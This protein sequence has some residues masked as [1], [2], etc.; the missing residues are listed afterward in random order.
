MKLLVL[1]VGNILASDDGFGIY[2][3]RYLRTNYSFSGEIDIIDAHVEGINLLNIFSG[4]DRVLVLDVIDSDGVYLIPSSQLRG[5]N[6][7]TA[8]DI[9]II[10]TLELYEMLEGKKLDVDILAIGYESIDDGIGL[11][12]KLEQNFDIFIDEVIKY[13]DSCNIKS[14][15][16]SNVSLRETIDIVV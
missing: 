1:G 9:G 4:Y 10:E 15:K 2:A 6:F 14:I 12:R 8:H 5:F 13:L 7:K 16:N 11:S 3:A